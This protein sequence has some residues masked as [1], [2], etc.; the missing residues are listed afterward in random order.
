MIQAD[1]FT[2]LGTN[3]ALTALVGTNVYPVVLPTGSALPAITYSITSNVTNGGYSLDMAWSSRIRLT[4]DVFSTTYLECNNIVA[5]VHSV[6]D[7]YSD[8]TIQL[9]TPE[10]EQDFYMSNAL[11]YRTSLDFYLYQ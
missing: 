4:I 1:I 2:L 5:A 9:I 11:I 10:N 8:E 6:L 7:G 3:S